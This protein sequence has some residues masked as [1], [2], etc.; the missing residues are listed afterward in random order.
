MDLKVKLNR[1]SHILGLFLGFSIGL[2]N[3]LPPKLK[4]G[5][6]R[7]FSPGSFAVFSGAAHFNS[8]QYEPPPFR[9]FAGGFP[10]RRRRRNAFGLI[11]EYCTRN[12]VRR[13]GFEPAMP[14]RTMDLQSI[15][16]DHSATYAFCFDTITHNLQ[17]IKEAE[18][19][20]GGRRHGS[21]TRCIPKLFSNSRELE[22][23]NYPSQCICHLYRT[24][25]F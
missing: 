8:A 15:A 22:S 4:Y 19:P 25:V 12:F 24:M 9:I 3:F 7:C 13:A 10:R 11:Q 2:K 18:W 5:S 16:I 20:W 1:K 21:N 17:K 23:K 6:S 14:V